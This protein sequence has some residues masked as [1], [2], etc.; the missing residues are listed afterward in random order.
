MQLGDDTNVA[1]SLMSGKLLLRAGD[2]SDGGFDSRAANMLR[3]C[4]YDGLLCGRAWNC[5]DLLVKHT[6]MRPGAAKEKPAPGSPPPPYC[7]MISAIFLSLGLTISSLLV[8]SSA[9]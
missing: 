4:L 9:Y 7:V 2:R 6:R 8:L 3:G 5:D 1:D